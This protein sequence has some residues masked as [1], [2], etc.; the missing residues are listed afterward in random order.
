MFFFSQCKGYAE[1]KSYLENYVNDINI[2][3]FKLV[4]LGFSVYKLGERLNTFA[5]KNFYSWSKFGQD[6]RSIDVVN[7]IFN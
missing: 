2:L 1:V 3:Q 6:I 5:N 4:Q 7:K